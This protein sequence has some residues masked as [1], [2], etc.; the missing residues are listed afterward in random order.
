MYMC[1]NV[2]TSLLTLLLFSTDKRNTGSN[3]VSNSRTCPTN[4]KG[5]ELL[6]C[7]SLY[8]ILYILTHKSSVSLSKCDE[9]HYFNHL[10][11]QNNF[12][13]MHNLT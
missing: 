12:V 2:Y 1:N 6:F 4:P 5:N 10:S 7:A 3:F 9:L 11:G 8:C 13:E